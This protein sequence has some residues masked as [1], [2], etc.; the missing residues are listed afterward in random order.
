MY[1]PR[2]QNEVEDAYMK[3]TESME[4]LI[5][6]HLYVIDFIQKLQF[7]KDHPSKRRR[8]KRDLASTDHKGLAGLK[9]ERRPEFPPGKES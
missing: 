4:A 6:G 7:R 9:Q 2:V 1:E 5:A 8:I 3:G